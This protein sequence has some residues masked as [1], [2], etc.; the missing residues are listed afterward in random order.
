MLRRLDGSGFVIGLQSQPEVTWMK[1][2]V[3]AGLSDAGCLLSEV[4]AGCETIDLLDHL[5]DNKDSQYL[6]DMQRWKEVNQFDIE[7]CL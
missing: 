7:I 2:G 3:R 4:D 1:W 5:N 6:S